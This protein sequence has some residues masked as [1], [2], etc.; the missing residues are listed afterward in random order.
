LSRIV[1]QV[2]AAK[3]KVER[4]LVPSV[5][6]GLG[7]ALR[8]P[9][10]AALKRA[11]W[12]GANRNF[13]YH[14]ATV[15]G[16]DL[17]GN[18]MV[19]NTDDFVQTHIALLGV[20][21]PSLTAYLLAK[22][23]VDGVFLDIGANVG[24]FSLLASRIFDKVIAFEPS[25]SIHASLLA[26]IALNSRSNITAVQTAVASERGTVEFYKAESI[27]TSSIIRKPGLVLEA[28]VP[29]APLQ[30]HLT[31]DDWRRVRFVKIDVE[32]AEPGVVESLLWSRYLL[33]PD[34]EISVE[35][36]GPEDASSVSVFRA[37]CD[38]GF[39]AFDFRSTYSAEHYLQ[40]PAFRL[41]SV[42]AVPKGQTDCL[43]RRA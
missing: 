43:F 41:T 2:R 9:I 6:R 5:V 31:N 30:D 12:R 37:F 22:K 17:L 20:W 35:M 10:P 40:R 25:P 32:G 13:L 14:R 11:L 21:E 39:R 42:T 7:F 16:S 34:V 18:R 8:R 1:D 15:L 4:L 24:Y 26:N 19:C 29:S 23:H 28:L 27:G 3:A 36:N 33:P 38:A